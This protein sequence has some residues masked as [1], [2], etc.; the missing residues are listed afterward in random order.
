MENFNRKELLNCSSFLILIEIK[1]KVMSYTKTLFY[2]KVVPQTG[3]LW[4]KH[5]LA[6]ITGLNIR[7]ISRY[8]SAAGIKADVQKPLSNRN[9]HDA[10]HYN[11][12]SFL[13]F[14]RWLANETREMY[15][16]K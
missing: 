9:N 15:P 14:M 13:K 16:C 12:E 10:A 1:I 2:P 4:N 5:Q 6:R 3:E 11:Q 7:T 8:L